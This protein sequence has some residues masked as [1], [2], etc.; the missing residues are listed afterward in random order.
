[1]PINCFLCKIISDSNILLCLVYLEVFIEVEC[2]EKYTEKYIN[3]EGITPCLF[4][5]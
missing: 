4:T 3:P 5:K 2:I 1:M